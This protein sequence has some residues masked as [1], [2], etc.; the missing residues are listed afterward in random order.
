MP[1]ARL[2]SN[3]RVT[4][5]VEIRRAMGLRRGES[6]IFTVLDGGTTVLRREARSSAKSLKK[7]AHGTRVSGLGGERIRPR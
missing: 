1:D 7:L 6:V 4:I 3:G 2:T 5:P